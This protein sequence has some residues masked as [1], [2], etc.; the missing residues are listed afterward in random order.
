[1]MVECN[2]PKCNGRIVREDG[3]VDYTKV[4][5]DFEDVILDIRWSSSI[6]VKAYI[7]RACGEVRFFKE[8]E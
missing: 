1:M 2:N 4:M 8:D 7:C 5:E 6:P 3:L